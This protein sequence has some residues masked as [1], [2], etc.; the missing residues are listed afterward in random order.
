MVTVTN[1]SFQDQ[2]A[3]SVY[4]TFRYPE[5]YYIYKYS[6]LKAVA[7]LFGMESKGDRMTTYKKI[8]DTIHDVAESDEELISMSHGKGSC[9]RSFAIDI[10]T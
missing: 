4:L 3:I 2:H 10:T 9:L 1:I 5:D 8:C 7:P 6:I